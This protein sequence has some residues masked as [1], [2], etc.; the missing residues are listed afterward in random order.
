MVPRSGQQLGQQDELAAGL[1]LSAGG[2][3]GAK[4]HYAWRERTSAIR[5]CIPESSRP[6]F[7]QRLMLPFSFDA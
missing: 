2:A 7:H 6:A 1:Q 3:K 5:M 4:P